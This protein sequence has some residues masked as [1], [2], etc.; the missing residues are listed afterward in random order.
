[1]N[2]LLSP[3][4]VELIALSTSD[5]RMSSSRLMM[6]WVRHWFSGTWCA[7]IWLS[8]GPWIVA[9]FKSSSKC[10]FNS[11][12]LGWIWIY[13]LVLINLRS[14]C[15]WSD[16]FLPPLVKLSIRCSVAW[17]IPAAIHHY[18]KV[19]I[20]IYWSWNIVVIFK[21]FLKSNLMIWSFTNHQIV[22]SFKSFKKLCQNLFFGLSSF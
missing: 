14:C 19:L 20:I 21:E 17:N 10:S 5:L 11:W 4:K 13:I 3:I 12:A 22:M 16:L 9:W 2:I 8:C 15:T 7:I 6:L 1:M 18:F